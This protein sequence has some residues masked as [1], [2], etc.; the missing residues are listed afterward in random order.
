MNVIPWHEL[1]GFVALWSL[2]FAC[3]LM[4]RVFEEDKWIRI[5]IGHAQTIN[6]HTALHQ[7]AAAA[8]PTSKTATADTKEHTR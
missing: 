7:A 2:G 3:Y 1:F 4:G 6:Q 5:L 8:S